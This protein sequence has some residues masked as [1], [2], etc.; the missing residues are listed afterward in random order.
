LELQD[1]SICLSDKKVQIKDFQIIKELGKGGFG[2]VFLVF[3]NSKAKE[4][5]YD[6]IK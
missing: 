5:L 4:K 3:L 1:Q 6:E 2:S